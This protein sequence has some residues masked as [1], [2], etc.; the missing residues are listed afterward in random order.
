MEDFALSVAPT[1]SRVDSPTILR[2]YPLSAKPAQPHANMPLRFGRDSV[3]MQ[4]TP[5]STIN[6]P[7]RFG[8]HSDNP[9]ATLPQM[10]DLRNFLFGDPILIL[11]SPSPKER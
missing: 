1:S 11:D 5:K 7:Q 10:F 8:R 3:N 6:L 2:L 4:R 9:S